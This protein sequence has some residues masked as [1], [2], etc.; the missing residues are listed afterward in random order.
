MALVSML[1]I[2][3]SRKKKIVGNDESMQKK[4]KEKRQRTKDR[5]KVRS[6]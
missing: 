6:T 4:K 1:S 2:L 3:Y 5:Q